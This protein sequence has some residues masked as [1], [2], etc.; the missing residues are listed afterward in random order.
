M[1]DGIAVLSPATKS[2]PGEDFTRHG[3]AFLD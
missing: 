1:V 3:D 2:N